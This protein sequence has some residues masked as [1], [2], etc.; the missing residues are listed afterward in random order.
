MSESGKVLIVEGDASLATQMATSLAQSGYVADTLAP[1]NVLSTEHAAAG[2]EYDLLI[3]GLD[4]N[5]D[6]P[7]FY[8]EFRSRNANAAIIVTAASPS[9]D[10]AVDCLK[11]G[12]YDYLTKPFAM[13]KLVQSTRNALE[14]RRLFLNIINL[15]E[16]LKEANSR[17]AR[18]KDEIEREKNLLDRLLMESNLASDTRKLAATVINRE[19]LVEDF[20]SLLAGFSSYDAAALLLC[21]KKPFLVIDEKRTLS[22]DDIQ[23][24]RE[25]ML[26]GAGITSRAETANVEAVERESGEGGRKAT[27]VDR[28]L[29]PLMIN[30]EFLGSI[31]V[32]SARKNR[33]TNE[34]K[35]FL[36]IMAAEFAMVA[37]L[38]DLY[39]DNKMLS[40]T[41]GLTKIFNNRHFQEMLARDFDRIKRYSG[42]LSLILLDVDNFKAINDTYG[43]QQGDI[44]LIELAL[45]MKKNTRKS[46]LVARYGGEEFVVVMPETDAERGLILAESLRKKIAEH[47]FSGQGA[48]RR[49]TVSIG[50][51]EM[52]ETMQ[53]QFELIGRADQSL[54]QAKRTGKNKVCF[55]HGDRIVDS[56]RVG[57]TQQKPT[58]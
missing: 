44:I 45:L 41:D 5:S 13:D 47:C 26:T 33:F 52:D 37:K 50:L 6:I 20:F 55:Y 51:A 40:V 31:A 32:F 1:A 29:M 49:V 34:V 18:Q 57:A 17:L 27:I 43:H 23:Q 15:S 8:E 22:E 53:D 42:K 12:A 46:D 9:L 48:C 38:F 39:E 25:T 2:K 56:P 24:I 28:Q 4:G 21:R 14:N 11:G 54:Y 3:V 58:L 36:R 35:N 19:R 7:K 30:D 16:E 10:T